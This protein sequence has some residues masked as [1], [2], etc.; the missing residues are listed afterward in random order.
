MENFHYVLKN[1]TLSKKSKLIENLLKGNHSISNLKNKKGL[2]FSNAVLTKFIEKEVK[3]SSS[4]LTKKEKRSIRT[5]SSGEQKKALLNYLIEN[6]PDFLVLESP[7]ESLD[8]TSVKELKERLINL[9]KKI[10][11]IQ[12]ISRKE[13]ILPII[14]HFLGIKKGKITNIIPIDNYRFTEDTVN[15]NCNI[16]KPITFYKNIPNLL[17][18]LQNVNVSYNDNHILNDI[19]WNINK[20]EFW[21]LIGP[22][23]SGKSTILSMIYGNNVKAFGQEVYLFGQKKGSGESIWEIKEKI[24]YF[25]PVMLELFQRSTTVKEMVISGFFDSIGLY[26]TPTI[27]K[28]KLAVEWLK[29]L[30][31]ESKSKELFQNL[32]VVNQRL[33]LIARAMIKHPPLLILDEPL[34]N[35]DDKSTQ[36]ITALINKIAQESNTTIIFVSHKTT[37]NLQPNFIYEL[38]PSQKGS[39]GKILK[40]N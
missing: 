3:H 25:N 4:T 26:K 28:E 16:P 36:I 20:N 39:I 22:N 14:T 30:D 5:F 21:Q 23:G 31:L 7:F 11:L 8:Q 24:G 34:I 10:T 33:V 19:N 38:I 6:N 35:L 29:L 40:S 17:I 18:S 32:S 13:E 9:S 2:L 37:K 15:F 1:T 12:I 27:L